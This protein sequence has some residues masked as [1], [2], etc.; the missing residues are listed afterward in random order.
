MAIALFA[1]LLAAVTL[2]VWQSARPAQGATA[3]E[4]RAFIDSMLP[5][6]EQSWEEFGVPVSVTMSQA[7]L[8]SGWGGSSLSQQYNAYF[9]I[10][11]VPGGSVSPYQSG[12]VPMQTK[13]Y[14]GGV[15]YT[16]TEYFRSYASPTDSLADHGYYLT[17]RGIYGAAFTVNQDPRL[18]AQEIQRAGYATDPNYAHLLYKVMVSS[19]LFQYDKGTRIGEAIR[20]T[21][22]VG[23]AAAPASVSAAPVASSPVASSPVA[24]SPV[25]SSPVASSSDSSIGATPTPSSSPT[26]STDPTVTTSPT[27]TPT[28][29]AEGIVLEEPP[30][31]RQRTQDPQIVHPAQVAPLPAGGDTTGSSSTPSARP[32]GR[33]VALP[34]TGD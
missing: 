25:A 27:A 4:Q 20:P 23:R 10:K 19:N 26:P 9:G 33:P 7:I 21:T 13:E 29:T 1:S 28:A 24:S 31:A 2:M 18:F 22:T 12:C 6:A 30:L 32:S 3:A 17:T 11:C 8:E 5:G 14:L 15:W 16:R 34:S